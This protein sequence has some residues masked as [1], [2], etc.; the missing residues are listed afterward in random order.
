M[1]TNKM[2]NPE[3]TPDQPCI[4]ENTL[5]LNAESVMPANEIA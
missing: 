3:I 4:F 2:T 5:F 1:T